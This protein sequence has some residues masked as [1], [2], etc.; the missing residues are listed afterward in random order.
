MTN[1]TEIEIK[2]LKKEIQEFLNG[3]AFKGTR[4]SGEFYGIKVRSNSLCDD[5][6]V[7]DSLRLDMEDALNYLYLKIKYKLKEESNLDKKTIDYGAH[8]VNIQDVIINVKDNILTLEMGGQSVYRPLDKPFKLDVRSLSE[9]L[10]GKRIISLDMYLGM[11]C[12][13][14]L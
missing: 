7:I 9:L 5:S 4:I 6:M 10:E 13:S 11:I 1:M 12:N 3:L 14:L 2:E 8:K